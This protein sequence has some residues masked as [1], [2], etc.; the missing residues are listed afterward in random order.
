[1]KTAIIARAIRARHPSG[2][3]IS[4]VGLRREESKARSLRP[5]AKEDAGL[6]RARG[7]GWS[8]NPIIDW[9]REDVLAYIRQC[10]GVLHEAYRI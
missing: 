2:P 10:G 3:V 4:A 7:L 9:T 8:W 5:V 6:S 1:M